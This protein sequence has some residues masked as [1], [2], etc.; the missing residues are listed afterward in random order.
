MVY[1]II[2]D[3]VEIT[4]QNMTEALDF[5]YQL[6]YLAMGIRSMWSVILTEELSLSSSIVLNYSIKFL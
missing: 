5:G 2:I 4:K 3:C 6:S 1:S